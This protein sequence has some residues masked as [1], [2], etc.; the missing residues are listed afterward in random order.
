M[1]EQPVENAL[2]RH[3]KAFHVS[4]SA[5]ARSSFAHIIGVVVSETT[6]ETA[7]AT[8]NVTANSRNRRPT[9]PA[10][11]QNRNEHRDQRD[12]DRD[13]RESDLARRRLIAASEGD[14]PCSR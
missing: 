11:Q 3:V 6:I 1:V 9:I 14:I 5:A 7:T 2:A 13:H 12:A 4:S 10:H 8:D